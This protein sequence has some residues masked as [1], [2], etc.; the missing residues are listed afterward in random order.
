M[1]E[2]IAKNKRR[3]LPCAVLLEGEYGLNDVCVGVPV[4]LGKN[5]V[6]QIL[7]IELS[8]SEKELL[9]KSADD[10]QSNIAKLRE[11]GF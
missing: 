10:V 6:E 1:V 3:I 4:K 8:D 2:S 11:L 7:E 9:K 5:G